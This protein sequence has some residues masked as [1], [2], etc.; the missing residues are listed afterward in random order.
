MNTFQST[1]RKMLDDLAQGIDYSPKGSIDVV[2]R[3]VVAFINNL[4]CY[5]TTSSCSGRISAFRNDTS[6]GSK[7]INWL[8]VKHSTVT[9]A[10]ILES[11]T[12]P[13]FDTQTEALTVLKCEGFILHVLC[14]DLAA[15]TDLHSKQ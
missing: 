8:V 4:D 2:I 9:S 6:A 14:R 3:P 7:G 1:K 15:A 10:E 5:V 13:C 11:C 12:V